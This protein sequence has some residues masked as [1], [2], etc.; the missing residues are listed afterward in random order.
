[1]G[2]IMAQ[3]I[4]P[5]TGRPAEP[6]DEAYQ[7]DQPYQDKAEQLLGEARYTLGRSGQIMKEPQRLGEE[8]AA[9]SEAKHLAAVGPRSKPGLRGLTDYYEQAAGPIGLASIAPPLRPLGAL[10]AGLL[11]PG[12]VRKA[13]A[14]QEDESRMAGLGQLGLAG[15]SLLGL[16]GS[17]AAKE[18]PAAAREISTTFRPHGFKPQA[19]VDEAYGGMGR[20]VEGL[21]T[22]PQSLQSI[23]DSVAQG[24]QGIPEAELSKFPE[25]R[26]Q[27]AS[28][29]APKVAKSPVKITRTP[30]GMLSKMNRESEAGYRNTQSQ[31][32][33]LDVLPESGLSTITP[34]EWQK[35]GMRQVSEHFPSSLRPV[36][37]VPGTEAGYGEDLLANLSR[38]KIPARSRAFAT[39]TPIPE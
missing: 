25:A 13:F 17:M 3:P 36:S 20:N 2:Q 10:E 23:I 1:L 28:A 33:N 9:A 35:L 21:N 15:L 18:A 7:W 14:P 6:G 22:R 8:A 39:N 26:R 29:T 31:G 4:E 19:V 34:S 5:R 11:I 32:A 24:K 37:P 12:G 27:F 16:K 38:L 30:K